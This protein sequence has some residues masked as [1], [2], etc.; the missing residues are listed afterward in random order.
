[1]TGAVQ[2]YRRKDWF[3]LRSNQLK[4]VRW[5]GRLLGP[6]GAVAELRTP[7]TLC[8]YDVFWLLSFGF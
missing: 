5:R 3:P 4:G 1:M 6:G 8:V 7:W 2:V